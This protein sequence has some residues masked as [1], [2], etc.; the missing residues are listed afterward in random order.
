MSSIARST[1][2]ILA[3]IVAVAFLRISMAIGNADP[4][5][6]KDVIPILQQHCQTCH[7]PGEIAPTSFVSYDDTKR[8]ASA[9]AEVTRTRKMPPWFADPKYG[10]F[11]NDPSVA[12]HEIAVLSSWAAAGAP[13]GN[14]QDAP[15]RPH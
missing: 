9:I 6:Y 2:V 5:F 3:V 11:S 8:W 7:R 13:A 12:P 4:T 1:A 14:R 15:A 10:T